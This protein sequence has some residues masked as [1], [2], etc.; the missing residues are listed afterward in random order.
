VTGTLI[1]YYS[2]DKEVATIN[3]NSGKFTPIAPGT[4]KISAKNK[5]GKVV[6]AKTFKVLQRATAVKVEDSE[7]SLS[8]SETFTL[9]AKKIPSTSTDVIRFYSS[10]RSVAV[11]GSI[12]GKIT[13]IEYGTT[14]IQVYSKATVATEKSSESNKVTTVTVHVCNKILEVTQTWKNQLTVKFADNITSNDIILIN[15]KENTKVPIQSINISNNIAVITTENDLDLNT[16][17]T[18]QSGMITYDF[19]TA[20]IASISIEPLTVNWSTVSPVYVVLKDTNGVELDRYEYGSS[21]PDNITF[22]ISVT[23]ECYFP[24]VSIYTSQ[25]L[26]QR[27]LQ[28]I[29]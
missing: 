21:I 15:K 12:N 20:T 18:V 6:A 17:Y 27:S 10:D 26:P 3:V 14:T 4:V 23:G 29:L 2:S 13:P 8:L 11:V 25:I 24:M 28:Y 5:Y 16:E 9:K 19:V 1:K 7:I 22:N